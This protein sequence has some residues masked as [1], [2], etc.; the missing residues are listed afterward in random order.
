MGERNS[1]RIKTVGMDPVRANVRGLAHSVERDLGRTHRKNATATMKVAKQEAPKDSGAMA[2]T[3]R[4]TRRNAL[5]FGDGNV[6]YVPVILSRV[7]PFI[8]IAIKKTL[9]RNNKAYQAAVTELIRRKGLD[10]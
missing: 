2:R 3:G 6:R 10:R 5:A 4:I 7:K 8:A 1:I 9:N